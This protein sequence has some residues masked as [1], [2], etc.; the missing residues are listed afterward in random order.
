MTIDE[1]LNRYQELTDSLSDQNN[2]TNP[3]ILSELGREISELEPIVKTH[4]E[5]VELEKKL[6]DEKSL[7]EDPEFKQI[8]EDEI[9]K[10]NTSIENCKLK[11]VNLTTPPSEEDIYDQNNA[12]VEVRGAAG[13]DEAK[14]WANDLLRMYSRYSEIQKYDIET[15]DEGVVKISGKGV[16]G[17]L[18]FESGAH[19]VQRVP[20]TENSGRIHTST[21]TVVVMPEIEQEDFF[22]NPEDVEFAACRSGG[23]GGQNVNK[24]STAVRLIHKPTGLVV[25]CQT[26]RYQARNR[27]IAMD[28]LR[29]KLWHMEEDK[30]QS[31]LS[32]ERR[33]LVGRGMRSEKI[34]TY[35]F[36]QDRVTDHRIDISWHHLET[37]LGGKIDEI[38]SA[39]QNA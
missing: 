15:L 22:L 24:V 11:I 12:I 35:N 13:G 7:L 36:P 34:R 28:L 9:S 32:E 33:T 39:L 25:T 10:L 21:A 16:Y 31:E 27:E 3:Q 6:N 17:K 23:H 1:I 4:N 19:R 14:I 20:T 5:Q 26:E 2:A 18:K 8:A 38:I 37:I 30:R 29:S